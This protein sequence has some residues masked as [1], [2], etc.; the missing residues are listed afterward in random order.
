MV[1]VC[2]PKIISKRI[3][4]HFREALVVGYSVLNNNKT[5]KIS[6]NMIY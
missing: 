2:G 3:S 4:H 5:N 1:T 6:Q